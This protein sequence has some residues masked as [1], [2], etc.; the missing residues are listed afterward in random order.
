MC[1]VHSAVYTCIIYLGPLSIHHKIVCT[2]HL[3]QHEIVE[4][5]VMGN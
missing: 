1:C 5:Q 3:V 2:V 4:T